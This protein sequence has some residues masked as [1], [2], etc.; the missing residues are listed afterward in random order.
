MEAIKNCDIKQPEATSRRAK[1]LSSDCTQ[2]FIHLY[3]TGFGCK[4]SCEWGMQER[5]K[6]NKWIFIEYLWH[7]N[8]RDERYM[9]GF[10]WNYFM[11]YKRL[12]YLESVFNLEKCC[13]L[14][15][16]YMQQKWT[17]DEHLIT[18]SKIVFLNYI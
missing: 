8:K 13:P 7:G 6:Y 1:L 14:Q 11:Y 17:N 16:C 12:L 3:L 9:Q 18:C 4:R 10:F 15:I 2:R 5:V